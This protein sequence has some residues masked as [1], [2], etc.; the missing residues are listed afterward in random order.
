M[1][2]KSSGSIQYNANS[3]QEITIKKS[4]EVLY[5]TEGASIIL[6]R[7]TAGQYIIIYNIYRIQTMSNNHTTI[8]RHQRASKKEADTSIIKNSSGSIQYKIQTT[9]KQLIT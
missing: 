7:K 5:I 3:E 9:N 8:K 2:K 6:K 4:Y 1:I